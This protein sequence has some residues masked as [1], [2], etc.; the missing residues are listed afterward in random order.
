VG[1]GQVGVGVDHLRLHPQP[2]LHAGCPDVVHQRVQAV[3]PD[4]LVDVPVAESG[5]VVAAVPE[6]AVVEHEPLRADLG[7]G[8]RQRLELP[9]VV[10]EVH[11]LPGVD[12]DRPG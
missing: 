5:V 6:P 12:D 10:V 11:R 4:P 9:E 2:E 3:R 1:P 7:G 8:V